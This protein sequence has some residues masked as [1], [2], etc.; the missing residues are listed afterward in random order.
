MLRNWFEPIDDWTQEQLAVAMA[1]AWSMPP[2]YRVT[3]QPQP[4]KAKRT[5][6]QAMRVYIQQRKISE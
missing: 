6:R 4:A 1:Q 3:Q 5:L 2:A